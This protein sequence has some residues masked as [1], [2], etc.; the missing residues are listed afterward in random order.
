MLKEIVLNR[1]MLKKKVWKIEEMV[2]KRVM[3]KDTMLKGVMWR[4]R[5]L[6]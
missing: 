3:L 4:E 6:K 1:V 5:V 2:L